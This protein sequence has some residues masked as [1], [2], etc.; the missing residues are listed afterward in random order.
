MMM[1]GYISIKAEEV[2]WLFGK[3]DSSQQTTAY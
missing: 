3:D 2:I 1:M